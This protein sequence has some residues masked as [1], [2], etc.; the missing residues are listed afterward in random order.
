MTAAPAIV[1]FFDEQPVQSIGAIAIDPKNSKNVWVG[2]GESW[3]RNS[4]SNGDGIYKSNDG[5]ETWTNA[6]LPKSERIAQIRRYSEKTATLFLPPSGGTLERLDDRGLYRTTDG[7]EEWEIALKGGNPSTGC[8]TVVIDP[9]DSNVMFAALWDFRRQRLDL[10]L[11]WRR[12]QRTV[13]QR[14]IPIPRRRQNLDTRSHR[15]TAKVSPKNHMVESRLQLRHRTRSAFMRPS[16][17]PTARCSFPMMAA[18]PGTSG[19]EQWM[20]WRPFYFA[21]LIVDPKNPDRVFKTDGSM[22]VS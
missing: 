13:W 11:R 20:V 14:V 18:A 16:N 21:N 9:N 8:S 5:G 15:R 3:T 4:V 17:R 22:I 6:G 7:G 10:S 1:R 2:T 19:Q 12:S